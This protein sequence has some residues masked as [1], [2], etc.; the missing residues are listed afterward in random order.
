M[1]RLENS[2]NSPKKKTEQI[3]ARALGKKAATQKKQGRKKQ[4]ATQLQYLGKPH[5]YFSRSPEP[6]P[7]LQKGDAI[8]STVD[9]RNNNENRRRR[10]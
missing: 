3:L 4:V 6:P 7:K 5:H 1:V 10:G 8:T 2:S 9:A